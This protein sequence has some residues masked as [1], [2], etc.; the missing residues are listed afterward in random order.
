[1]LL[2]GKSISWLGVT[3]NQVYAFPILI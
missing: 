3:M 1:M 2:Q